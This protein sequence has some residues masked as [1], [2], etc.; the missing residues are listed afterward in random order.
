MTQIVLT[1]ITANEL[2]VEQ[3]INILGGLRN[4]S[5][6]CLNDSEYCTKN[7]ITQ[8]NKKTIHKLVVGSNS[9]AN[10]QLND[11]DNKSEAQQS[12][13][14]SPQQQP[15]T[16]PQLQSPRMSQI[17]HNYY[18]SQSQSMEEFK[19]FKIIFTAEEDNNLY[20]KC[21]P[22]DIAYSIQYEILH[23]KWFNGCVFIFYLMIFGIIYYLDVSNNGCFHA[24]NVI[25]VSLHFVLIT[26]AICM[27]MAGNI[28]VVKAI[29]ESFDF[30]FKFYNLVIYTV[31]SIINVDISSSDDLTM[32]RVL[33][34]MSGLVG[35]STAFLLDAVNFS[36]STK[37]VVL[38]F[39]TAVLILSWLDVWMTIDQNKTQWNPFRSYIDHDNDDDESSDIYSFTTFNFK[40]IQMAAL[41]N[42]IIF[43]MKPMF[44]ALKYKIKN[45]CQSKNSV[46]N[47]NNNNNNNGSTDQ[48]NTPSTSVYKKPYFKWDKGVAFRQLVPSQMAS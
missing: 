1:E 14:T 8:E 29:F 46:S 9:D 23:N 33:T 24:C 37:L 19:K 15:Q 45:Q 26:H 21:L 5:E 20:F 18:N 25:K 34:H 13:S 41:T 43:S 32:A 28:Y 11:N 30:W 38:F 17:S 22:D 12:P 47:Q 7:N 40:S 48:N 4:V 16:P 2:N 6:H 27:C 42:L 31:A 36:L 10:M 35:I 44:N 39:V 3:I